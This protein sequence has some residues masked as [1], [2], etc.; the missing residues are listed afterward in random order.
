MKTKILF[1]TVVFILML[2]SAKS[3]YLDNKHI[4]DIKSEYLTI[5]QAG[6]KFSK[7]MKI[8]V[9]FGAYNSQNKPLKCYLR[10]ENNKP[11]TYNS[12]VDALNYLYQFNYECVD[13]YTDIDVYYLLKKKENK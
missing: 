3:Q 4:N 5:R 9:D 10:D 8:I 2:H 11:M 13:T 1:L 12:I 7:K 6:F